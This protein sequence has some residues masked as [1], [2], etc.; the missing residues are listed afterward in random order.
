MSRSTSFAIR[1]TS[2][3]L[4]IVPSKRPS[5]N[6]SMNVLTPSKAIFATSAMNV[7]DLFAM[8][9]S[10]SKKSFQPSSSASA[11]D[12]FQPACALLAAVTRAL[13]VTSLV[14]PSPL[15]PS[16]QV[17]IARALASMPGTPAAASIVNCRY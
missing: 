17:L 10:A 14:V 9:W 2:R 3:M 7:A 8:V 1:C 16:D 13:A 4:R 15:N 11:R 6:L 5:T 12:C